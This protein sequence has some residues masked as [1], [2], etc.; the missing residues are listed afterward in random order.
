[1]FSRL[2]SELLKRSTWARRWASSAQFTPKAKN[3]AHWTLGSDATSTIR[4]PHYLKHH[5]IYIFDIYTCS[6]GDWPFDRSTLLAILA[7]PSP[8]LPS[9]LSLLSTSSFNNYLI[10]YHHSSENDK[11]LANAS[12]RGIYFGCRVWRRCCHPSRRSRPLYE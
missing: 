6:R 8:F 5:Y 10:I 1:M 12:G 3:S 7:L 2:R 4:T 11:S 9:S